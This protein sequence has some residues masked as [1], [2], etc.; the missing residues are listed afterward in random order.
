M[1]TSPQGPLRALMCLGSV[2][3]FLLAV[4]VAVGR[5]L[6]DFCH[7]NHPSNSHRSCR[8][9]KHRQLGGAHGGLQGARLGRMLGGQLSADLQHQLRS[10]RLTWSPLHN[11][12]EHGRQTK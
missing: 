5:A 11:L 9:R 4:D 10:R 7:T 12:R 3:P 1:S 8:N 2:A 6:V